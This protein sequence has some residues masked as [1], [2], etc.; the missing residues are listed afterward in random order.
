MGSKEEL[1]LNLISKYQQYDSYTQV[2]RFI[3]NIYNNNDLERMDKDVN[4]F[5][6]QFS[7]WKQNSNPEYS[8]EQ[9]K[10]NIQ[11]S[12]NMNYNNNPNYNNYMESSTN[13]DLEKFRNKNNLNRSE[14]IRQRKTLRQEELIQ[15]AVDDSLKQRRVSSQINNNFDN[16][17]RKKNEFVG[18]KNI[19]NTCYF[20]SLIQNLFF[21]K[22]FRD[23]IL[24]F[25]MKKNIQPN[26]REE[27]SI[28]MIKE[29]QN[30]FSLMIKGSKNFVNPENILN[31]IFDQ[32]NKKVDIGD[33]KDIVEFFGYFHEQL[34]LADKYDL[35]FVSDENKKNQSLYVKEKNKDGKIN[36]FKGKLISSTFIENK[37]DK[38]FSCVGTNTEE[39]NPIFV[40]VDEKNLN[41]AL[42]NTFDYKIE[43]LKY[44]GTI[45]NAGKQEWLKEI[46][47]ILI[48]QVNRAQY[49][50]YN[51]S[52]IKNNDPFEF[53]KSF[54]I[55]QFMESNIDFVK[56]MGKKIE[57]KIKQIDQ[58]ENIESDFKKYGTKHQ[59]LLDAMDIV[60]DFLKEQDKFKKEDSFFFD[61]KFQKISQKKFQEGMIDL[62]KKKQNLMIQKKEI[63]EDINNIYKP[64][65]K[66]KYKLKGVLIHEGSAQF[67]HY[68]TYIKQNSK[69][70]CFND[71]NVSE[72]SEK[73]V[74]KI[75]TGDG[76]SN[77]NCYCLIYIHH[78]IDSNQNPV[79]KILPIHLENY[80]LKKNNEIYHKSVADVFDRVINEFLKERYEIRNDQVLLGFAKNY[81]RL[82]S[83]KIFLNDSLEFSNYK[84]TLENILNFLIINQII[85][86]ENFSEFKISQ[87]DLKKIN[88]YPEIKKIFKQKLNQYNLNIT[89]HSQKL[90][91]DIDNYKEFYIKTV[92]S[93]IILSSA[94][95][96]LSPECVYKYL[97]LILEFFQACNLNFYYISL[98]YVSL[99][100]NLAYIIL[101]GHFL[102]KHHKDKFDINE[103]FKCLNIGLVIVS[104]FYHFQKKDSDK[105]Y[106]DLLN[107][108]KE[109]LKDIGNSFNTKITENYLE[110][111][112]NVL[113]TK[114]SIKINY[115]TS[116]LN[117]K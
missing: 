90:D 24:N 68:Y 74:F 21:I 89:D 49:D 30:L 58:L 57:L 113:K 8:Y 45:T 73:D 80:V 22:E 37:N 40:N 104:R 35:N 16:S 10:N 66:N 72:I 102:W 50:K 59:G 114:K 38:K 111:F 25:E 93:N 28:N 103:F 13:F 105:I 78:S 31:N 67:G 60:N 4:Y 7:K 18:I 70:I 100:I 88:S 5:F 32:D 3:D 101:N 52:L 117:V 41:K 64:I 76:F 69:W 27:K 99:V 62:K 47:K 61:K 14:K 75:G 84:D 53:D 82:M 1:K 55:D 17:L 63:K 95:Q 83:F 96:I 110:N 6:Q 116:A 112:K 81:P 51:N 79:E 2:G 115:K 48:V 98:I 33:Q 56:E 9:R 65:E 97:E 20:N 34:E 43:N 15:K 91:E 11:N 42:K 107:L 39:F 86:K 29:I 108:I 87:L 19:G 77:K 46:P 44:K 106:L 92:K 23:K 26:F 94:V 54:F 85:I 36:L 109:F 12:T 71:K